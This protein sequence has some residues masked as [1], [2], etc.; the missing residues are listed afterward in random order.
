MGA[1]NQQERVR[2]GWIVGFVDGEGTFSITVQRNKEMSLGWQVFPEFVVTQ[3]EKNLKVLRELQD[4]FG[5][6]NVYRNRRHDNHKEDIFRYCVR[7]TG[8]LEQVIVPFFKQN[9]LKTSKVEDFKKFVQALKLIKAKKHLT[10]S[11]LAEIAEIAQAMNNKRPSRFLLSS[12][13]V[14]QTLHSE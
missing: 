6:G 9:K 14:R 8:D 12:E 10:R 5:C 13:T 4:F 7:K 2:R 11:G 3:G 1:D